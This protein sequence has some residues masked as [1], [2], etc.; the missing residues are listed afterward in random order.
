M[1]KKYKKQ[2]IISSIAILLPIAIGLI[3][4]NQLPGRFATHWGFNGEAD[5]WSGKAFA[6]FVPPLNILAVHWLCIWVTSLDPKATN[7]NK[8][9]FNMIFWICPI[10]SIACSGMMFAIAL[11]TEFNITSI[12]LPGMA[13]SFILIGNYMPKCRQNHTIGIKI[14][15]TLANEDNWN[16][17]HRFAGKLWV[18]CGLGMF[19]LAFLP[20]EMAATPMIL[21]IMVM[22]F[23]PTIYS[24]AYYKKQQKAGN[25][26]E[27]KPMDKTTKAITRGAYIFVAVIL[28]VVAIILLT[29]KIDYTFNEDSFT[30]DSTFWN[31]LTVDY[32]EISN[33]EL[34]IGGVDGTR[35]WGFG[36]WKLLLGAFENKEFGMYT[37]YTYYEPEACIVVTCGE[38]VLVLSGIDEAE[39]TAIYETLAACVKH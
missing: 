12:L 19:F 35:T 36:S 11:G 22:G 39:T 33:I 29:G 2:L 30:V 1:I 27:P 16:V 20:M 15:W 17:T 10:L 24:W 8:K 38:K 28:I 18:I 34:R 9:V 6:V 7:Q 13:I 14:P 23:V 31:P 32:E 37:R 25:H 5:G 21:I 4:W 26:Y 3:L